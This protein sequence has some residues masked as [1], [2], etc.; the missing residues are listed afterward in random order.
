M[1]TED[2]CQRLKDKKV[3]IIGFN[4]RPIA[5]S[6]KRLGAVTYVSDYWGDLDLAACSDEWIS[7]LSPIPG[8]R[9][10]GSLED[11]VHVSLTDNFLTEFTDVGFDYV[12]IGSG[13]DDHPDSLA[14]ISKEFSLTGNDESQFRRARNRGLI[15]KHLKGTVIRIPRQIQC[16]SYADVLKA[17]ERIGF[18]CVV[19]PRTSGGGSGIRLF[20]DTGSLEQYLSH[21]EKFNLVVQ[22]Y[23]LGRDLS[24]SVLCTGESSKVISLQGQ[25]IGMPSAGRNCDFV[26]CGNYI[27]IAVEE[28]VSDLVR[29]TSEVLTKELGLVGSNGID[30]VVADD[31]SV[32]LLEINPRLQGTLELLER[33]G[34]ISISEAHID[35]VSGHLPSNTP[36][37]KPTVKM[38]VYARRDGT[39]PDLQQ[40]PNSVDRSPEGVV[41]QTGDPICTIVESLNDLT[42]TYSQVIRVAD[43]IQ[44]AL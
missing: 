38:V 8:S 33:A 24:V 6:V 36:N 18:P 5:C 39:V 16:A 13:F 37:W 15:E 7:V 3:G 41:V 17:S 21:R 20:H 23:I 29:K 26:Y 44:K 11:P 32:Y 28:S 31:L 40:Y 2:F 22:E 25:L 14:M 34:S 19:R 27:P 35:A 12:L 43:R 4:A 1:T 42:T 10:R 9:Q 30:F